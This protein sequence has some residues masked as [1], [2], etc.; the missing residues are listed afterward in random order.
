MHCSGVSFT[1]I[2]S[3]GVSPQCHQS[4]CKQL[5]LKKWTI[6]KL[7][8]SS[9]HLDFN[10]K[11]VNKPMKIFKHRPYDHFWKMAGYYTLEIVSP[12]IEKS[13]RSYYSD[14]KVTG[15]QKMEQQT[16]LKYMKTKK[17]SQGNVAAQS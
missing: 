3:T 8:P 7:S 16:Q 2:H 14:D 5:G 6:Y 4:L 9:S 13:V 1:F 10:L 12:R 17:T 15:T 11:A